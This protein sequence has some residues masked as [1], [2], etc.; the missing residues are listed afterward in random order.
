MD[1]TNLVFIGSAEDLDRAFS[2]AGWT[3]SQSQS[4]GAGLRAVRAI[5]E[6]HAF[7]GAPMRTLLL[8][9]AEPDINR[10]KAL[11]TFAKRDHVR[12][13]K[14]ADQWQG[15]TVW[16]SAATRDV[17]VNFS[18]R[19]GFTHEIQ[20]EVDLERDRVVSD[21]LF[22][23]CVA[24]VSYVSRPQAGPSIEDEG[25]KGVSTD[26][27]VAVLALNSCETPRQ[28]SAI[29]FQNLQIPLAVRCV[30]RATLV[31]RNHVLRDHLLWRRAEAAWMAY[32]IIRNWRAQ[33]VARRHPG[34]SAVISHTSFAAN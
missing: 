20:N 5:A 14:R 8:D 26:G 21:L 33:I 2:A 15:Q 4:K 3:G 7:A 32:R 29:Q 34:P 1:P 13:W 27:R 16:A 31:A 23:G 12:M 18:L 30:R 24:S 6:S 9:G 25:R 22:T 11:N 10:Q 17:G 19:Y 28:S